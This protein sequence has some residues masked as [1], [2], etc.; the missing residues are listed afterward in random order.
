MLPYQHLLIGQ[1][2]MSLANQEQEVN[3]PVKETDER[4][5]F[6]VHKMELE[7]VK[8]MLKSYLRTRL[9]KIEKHLLYLV[10][11]DHASL[12]SEGEVQYAW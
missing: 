10:E 11:K 4:F 9:F 5:Y 8:Y 12:L 6:N 2:T 7:R 3:I 1:L